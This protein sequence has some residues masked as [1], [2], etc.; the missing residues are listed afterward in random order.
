MNRWAFVRDLL[1]LTLGSIIEALSVV[2][3]LVP[4]DIAPTGVSGVAV[5]LHHLIHTP[6]GLITLIGNIPIQIFAYRMLGGGRVIVA[7][8]YSVIVFTVTIDLF[9]YVFNAGGL[10]DEPLLNAVFGGI[11]GGIGSGMIYLAGG[12]AGGTT[13][14][15]R[16]LQHRFG[17]PFSTAFLYT[18][19]SS[20]LAVGA[21]FGWESALLAIVAVFIGGL[22]TDYLLEGPSVVRT[23][24]IITN[25]PE[26]IAKIIIKELHRGVTGWD[27]RGMYTGQERHILFVVITRSQVNQVRQLI[28][29]VDPDAFIVI[30]H[31]H[32]AYGEGF[33]EVKAPSQTGEI[34]LS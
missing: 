27:G 34:V 3:F 29:S 12:T 9:T 13:T 14:L 25:K 26:L 20:V 1:L 8:V 5:I 21:V 17:I 24:T 28:F 10:S 15:A 19:A 31:G 30:G 11:T 22:A 7:T 32:T 2:L 18:D 4:S 33:K 23:V 6:I 16:I